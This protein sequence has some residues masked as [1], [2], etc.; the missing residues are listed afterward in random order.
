M[1]HVYLDTE[2]TG[3]KVEE[4]H[5]IIEVGAVAYVDRKMLPGDAGQFQ[6][7]F[8]PERKVDREAV[9]V[10][11][12]DDDALVGKP[13]FA[14]KADRLIG[15][16]SGSRL[17]MHNARFDAE[18]LD[19]ELRRAGK[20]PLADLVEEIV[21]TLV[22]A[23]RRFPSGGNSLDGLCRR[24][25]IDASRRTKHGAMLDATL[26]AE[27]HLAMTRGQISIG[28]FEPG[29]G[30]SGPPVRRAKRDLGRYAPRLVR[31]G[32]AELREHHAWLA[33][34]RDSSGADLWPDGQ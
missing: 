25:G 18:F 29:E 2:T 5:R 28:E 12:V 23:R 9:L 26:L 27:I 30:Q 13:R 15:F 3:L 21:D 24:F 32:E 19:M 20:P 11:G 31:A 22:L 34:L 4:G 14:E 8:N 7:Y 33:E 1:K 10:H 16:I 17:L 6:C